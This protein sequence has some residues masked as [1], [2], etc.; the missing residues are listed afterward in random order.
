MCRLPPRQSPLLLPFPVM[1]TGDGG[2]YEKRGQTDG[3]VDCCLPRRT[4]VELCCNIISYCRGWICRSISSQPGLLLSCFEFSLLI[5]IPTASPL[6]FIFQSH[7]HKSSCYCFMTL[8]DLLF[9]Q[10]KWCPVNIRLVTI[11][12][13]VGG[14]SLTPS[15]PSPPCPPIQLWITCRLSTLLM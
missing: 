13:A 2:E 12:T 15:N 11:T 9:S 10:Q 3:R 6:C 7:Q 5:A 14:S 4:S 1:W 8:K